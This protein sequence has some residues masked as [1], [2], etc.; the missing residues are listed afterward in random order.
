MILPNGFI[1]Y[2]GGLMHKLII[3]WR[4]RVFKRGGAGEGS[5][6]PDSLL[7]GCAGEGRVLI[8]LQWCCA[9]STS[10]RLLLQAGHLQGHC[11]LIL[12]RD[13]NHH[14]PC[15]G[16]RIYQR[17]IRNSAYQVLSERFIL[18]SLWS[19]SQNENISTACS[20]SEEMLAEIQPPHH[21]SERSSRPRHC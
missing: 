17:L 20:P 8:R 16:L 1:F 3:R 14:R 4:H 12:Y 7:L 18:C 11:T 5:R 2:L 13:R 9:L 15:D 21:F 19:A 6:S 10:T